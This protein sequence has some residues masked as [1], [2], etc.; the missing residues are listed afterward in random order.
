MDK[1]YIALISTLSGTIIGF[2]LGL[3]ADYLRRRRET[4]E[5][6]KFI[7]SILAG[8]NKEIDSAI[9]RCEMLVR[10][11][12]KED[13]YSF[14]HI[15]TGY[16]DVL[17][18]EVARYIA[19]ND[20]LILL[21]RAYQIFDLVNFNL[22]RQHINDRNLI[23]GHGMAQTYLKELHEINIQIKEA[24]NKITIKCGKITS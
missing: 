23:A 6:N 18:K 16:W 4:I 24:I 12:E 17:R 3:G 19:D 2:L 5:R 7:I 9:E 22:D 20:L 21:H 15:Y 11:L 10:V 14:S 1:E 8:V 13:R